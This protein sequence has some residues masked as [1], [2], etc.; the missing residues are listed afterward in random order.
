MCRHQSPPTWRNL[1]GARLSNFIQPRKRW[2][3]RLM[4]SSGPLSS[5]T[6]LQRSHVPLGRPHADSMKD[7]RAQLSAHPPSAALIGSWIEANE[8]A[9]SVTSWSPYRLSFSRQE[10][11]LRGM[12]IRRM[13]SI[14]RQGPTHGA[15]AATVQPASGAFKEVRNRPVDRDTS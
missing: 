4:S 7:G 11:R 9:C 14:C 2:L 13:A 10:I 15:V 1:D 8:T 6:P 5:T 3:D 12:L